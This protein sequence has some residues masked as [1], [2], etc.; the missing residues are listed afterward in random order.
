MSAIKRE[1]F[2]EHI[3][4]CLFQAVDSKKSFYHVNKKSTPIFNMNI[5][6]LSV[7]IAS[8]TERGE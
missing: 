8:N 2:P 4:V 6:D 5:N 7:A 1:A 3:K